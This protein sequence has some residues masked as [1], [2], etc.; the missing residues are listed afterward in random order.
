MNIFFLKAEAPIFMAA[1]E[2]ITLTWVSIQFPIQ[3]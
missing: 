1:K 2:M 3:K